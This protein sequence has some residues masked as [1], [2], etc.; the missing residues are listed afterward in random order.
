MTH[1]NHIHFLRIKGLSAKSTRSTKRELVMLRVMEH[2]L[3][4]RVVEFGASNVSHIDPTKTK[5]NIILRGNTSSGAVSMAVQALMQDVR[6]SKW[7]KD[8]ISAIELIFSLPSEAPIAHHAYFNDAVIWAERFF[9]V[10]IVSAVIHF[11][12]DAPHC[13][14]I[15]IPIKSDRLCG[16]EVMG[17]KKRILAM[18]DDFYQQVG[19]QYG[20][21]RQ[22]PLKRLS[23]AIR[24]KAI[25]AALA[26]LE[27]NSGLRSDIL[28]VLLAP[29]FNNPEPIMQALG[30]VMPKPKI[31]GTFAGIMT[32]PVK[33]RK[34]SGTRKIF[35]AISIEVQKPNSIE[36]HQL[37]DTPKNQPLS[38]VEVDFSDD[39]L[40]PDSTSIQSSESSIHREE[41]DPVV[42]EDEQ[43][44]EK[45]HRESDSECLAC[46]FDEVTGEFVKPSVKVSKTQAIQK[47]VESWL[48]S[49]GLHVVYD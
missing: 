20:L 15:L 45:Y 11:D 8:T 1:D 2:N 10:P 37:N 9:Q 41:I 5:D 6:V 46:Y 16:S 31:K 14:T 43:V 39:V 44:H 26:V 21:V 30:L 25:D 34:P 36:I 42:A 17:N 24:T 3:R 22:S 47:E 35:E 33:E 40:S 18:Q 38:C 12:E 19:N 27:V 48:E 7:R 23:A 4:E 28:R 32:K 49:E 13:H 29:H